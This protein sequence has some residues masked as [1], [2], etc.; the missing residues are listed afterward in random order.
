MNNIPVKEGRAPNFQIRLS[1]SIVGRV[2]EYRSYVLNRTGFYPN[3][4]EAI[5][6]LLDQAL[7]NLGLEDIPNESQPDEKDSR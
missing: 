5:R 3:F 2:E 1:N 7:K 4:N 6:A